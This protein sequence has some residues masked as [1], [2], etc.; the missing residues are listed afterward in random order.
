VVQRA[1]LNITPLGIKNTW[2]KTSV[3][4]VVI[5]NT[6]HFANKGSMGR[7]EGMMNCLEQTIP[8][9]QITIVHRYYKQD[10]DTFV[11]QLLEKYPNLEV[12]E[13]PWF[14]EASSSILTAIGSLIRFC[15]LA[16]WRNIVRIL[17]L[18]I[19]D[20][21]QRYDVIVDL[22]II[23][24]AEGVYFTMTV[25][26]F[27]ALLNTWYA[28]MT[29]KPVIVCSATI[30]PYSGR[31]WGRVLRSLASYVLNKV[32]VITLREEFSQNYL[33]VLGVNKPRV[34]LSTDLA[35]LL[36]PAEVNKIST[37]LESI[38]IT[39]TDN[40]LVGIAPTAMMHPSLERKRYIQLIAELSDFLIEDLDATVVFITHTY[41]DASIT[42]SI[43][44][45]VKNRQKV[46]LLPTDLSASEVKGIIGIC[47]MFIS[48]RFHALVASTS[49][50][51]P[52]LGMVSYSKVKFHG[53][54]GEMMGQK[55]YLLDIDDGF[56]Y[57]AFLAE[58]KS[59]VKDLWVNRGLIAEDLK[60]R[61]R[62]A[63]EQV[64]LNG[65][66]IRELVDS[67]L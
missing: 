6:T 9:P 28:T 14:R 57:D 22:N 8:H 47:D 4:K 15:L 49:M 61:G 10:K 41:Q 34:Y 1:L 3:T 37:V 65:S 19:K 50:A 58:L 52:S 55:N 56:D 36:E 59:K 60:D 40:P 26:E 5:L 64:L 46:R 35:F 67:S 27:F 16:T 38:N 21:I 30:G 53:I 17:G 29:G 42:R 24:P 25:G 33:Q 48:S 11:K 31:F 44:H 54:I 12:K 2:R 7:I 66:L 20:E 18:P 39:P 13:H 23:E 43:Y 63:K 32:D 51:V 62:I 45:E